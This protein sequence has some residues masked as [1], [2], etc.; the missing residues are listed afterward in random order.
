MSR[1]IYDEIYIKILTS[2]PNYVIT[3]PNFQ[4]W[5]LGSSKLQIY[6]GWYPPSATRCLVNFLKKSKI[7]YS[8]LNF[9]C[10]HLRGQSVNEKLL[11]VLIEI[12]NNNKI[13]N[14]FL[15]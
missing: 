13:N 7:N 1:I 14:Y 6:D 15:I 5:F 10:F 8:F 4:D 2:Q 12:L 3:L 11:R 9:R